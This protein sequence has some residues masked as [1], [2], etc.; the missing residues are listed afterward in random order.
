MDEYI[1][2]KPLIEEISSLSVTLCGHEIFG[3]LAKYSVVKM[4][5]EHPAADVVEVR[6]GNWR[7]SRTPKTLHITCPLCNYTKRFNRLDS[8][9]NEKLYIINDFFNEHRF[10]PNCGAKMDGE[11]KDGAE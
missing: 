8:I 4:I 6:H 2:R 3:E 10:C 7:V 5:C 11:R 9:T 1:K